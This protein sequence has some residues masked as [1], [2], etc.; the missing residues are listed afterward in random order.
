MSKT[1]LFQIIQFSISTQFKCKYCLIVK[2][3]SI[4]NYS[5][6]SNNSVQHKYAVSSIQPMNRALL[7]ATTPGQGGPGSDG[8]EGVLRIPQ[9]SST[10]GTSP[11]D[12]LVLYPG[13]SLGGGSYPSAEVQSVYSTAP[14]DWAFLD[15]ITCSREKFKPLISTQVWQDP[16]VLSY[17]CSVSQINQSLFTMRGV[18]CRQLIH[19]L[20]LTILKH[21]FWV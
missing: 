21:M 20:P 1:V 11:S 15:E 8:N 2:N 18:E 7:G 6:Y 4:S 9:S 19:Q 10:A 5:V 17:V 14:A 16:F 13:H 12:C 3:I